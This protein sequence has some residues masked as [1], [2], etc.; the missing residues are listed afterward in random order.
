M[1]KIENLRKQAKLNRRWHRDG[2]FPVAAQIRRFLARYRDLSDEEI[3]E[4]DFKLSDAQ[5]LVAHKH[6]FENWPA[7]IEGIKTMATPS[8]SPARASTI[9]A[10]EPQLFVADIASACRFYTE[11]FGFRIG[12]SYGDPPFYAQIC[13]DGGS[14]NLRQVDGPVFDNGFRSQIPDAL[15]ATLIL[16]NAKPLFLEF[17]KA[18]VTFHQTLRTEPWGARTFIVRDPDGNLICFAGQGG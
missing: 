13:R 5:E 17:Q 12:F 7:L 11:K 4:A 10:A 1:P 3:L 8:A 16:D 6:G 2:Y 18:N 15:S 14:L 9:M